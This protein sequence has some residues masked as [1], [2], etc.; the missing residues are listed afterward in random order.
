MQA[1]EVTKM[2]EQWKEEFLLN[3]KPPSEMN[4]QGL[5]TKT[6]DPI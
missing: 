2:W 6:V 1:G 5:K 4:F 3:K